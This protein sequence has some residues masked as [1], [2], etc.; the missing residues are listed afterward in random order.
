MTDWSLGGIRTFVTGISDEVGQTIARLQPLAGKTVQQVFGYETAV[1]KISTYI[2]GETDR[3]ALEAMTTTGSGYELIS[4]EGSI[5]TFLVQRV[6]PVRKDSISQTLRPD[7]ACDA[8]VYIVD[9][10]LLLDA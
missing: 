1:Y 4:P 5:G 7:L 6:T 2:V 8:P 10:G 3:A 9:I